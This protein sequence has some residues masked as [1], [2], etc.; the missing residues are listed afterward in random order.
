VFARERDGSLV[1]LPDATTLSHRD[2]ILRLAAQHRLPAVYPYRFFVTSG[3]LIF[4]GMDY[5]DIFLRAPDYLDRILKG[6]NPADLP[7]QTPTKL[8]LV[9]NL[10]TAK[11]LD[12][13]VPS[14]LVPRADD[15]I[16]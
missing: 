2:L 15:V 16:E 1:A 11:A 4:Y 13:T 6:E 8:E 14:S 3:E 9:I 12:L 10:K 5:A 7:I